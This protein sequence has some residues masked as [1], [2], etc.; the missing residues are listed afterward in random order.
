[1]NKNY[2][3]L[4]IIIFILL[5]CLTGFVAWSDSRRAVVVIDWSTASEIDIVGFNIYRGEQNEEDFS[6]IN[7]EIIPASQEP[8]TGGNYSFQ[9]HD[10]TPGRV[11]Y[12]LLEDVSMDGGVSR[13]GPIEVKAQADF[14]LSLL[15][16]IT[17]GLSTLGLIINRER[18][19]KKANGRSEKI[20]KSVI[21]D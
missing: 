14:W 7:S 2:F 17:F 5:T 16:S 3:R 21:N 15:I 1:M 11:Y 13:N 19:L 8:L 18:M 6:K 12:Y 10:V 4:L 20:P 9:D